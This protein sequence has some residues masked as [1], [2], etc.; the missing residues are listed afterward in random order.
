[1]KGFLKYS[2]IGRPRQFGLAEEHE[3]EVIWWQS[4]FI[5]SGYFCVRNLI[6]RESRFLYLKPSVNTW[7]GQMTFLTLPVTGLYVNDDQ[8]L[9]GTFLV[10][11]AVKETSCII[12]W[13]NGNRGH[14]KQAGTQGRY[15]DTKPELRLCFWAVSSPTWPFLPPGLSFLKCS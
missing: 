12:C 10:H 14:Q 7:L 9:E 4:P 1:M 5:L 13:V 11:E 3:F 8:G 6:W 15:G 2:F